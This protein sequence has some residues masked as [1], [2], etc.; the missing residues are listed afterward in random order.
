MD[1]LHNAI[2][3]LHVDAVAHLEGALERAEAHYQQAEAETAATANTD[4][5]GGTNGD[6][7]N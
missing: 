5:A 1:A 6:S 2:D 3:D 4:P 7:T